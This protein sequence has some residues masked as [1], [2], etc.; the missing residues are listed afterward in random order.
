VKFEN[1]E[2]HTCSSDTRRPADSGRAAPAEP[3]RSVHFG[4]GPDRGE[5]C[6]LSPGQAHPAAVT[7][8]PEKTV[9]AQNAG[10]L[11]RIT[12]RSP[13]SAAGGRRTGHTMTRPSCTSTWMLSRLGG[14]STRPADASA[15]DHRGGDGGRGV[16]AAASY[17]CDGLGVRSA[18]PMRNRGGCAADGVSASAHLQRYQDVSP[19]CSG[20]FRK[21]PM[22]RGCR[23]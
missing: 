16:V 12:T 8:R 2:H 9:A 6:H 18:M 4:K 19:W 17:E 1:T 11:T 3:T 22:C 21:H 14:T 7:R 10:D 13:S 15:S 23:G 20:C 5:A